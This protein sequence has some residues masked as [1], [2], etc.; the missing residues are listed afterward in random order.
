M[1]KKYVHIDQ[2]ETGYILADDVYDDRGLL[3]ISKD[4]AI[5]DYII[6]KLDNFDIR[7]LCVYEDH[8]MDKKKIRKQYIEHLKKDYKKNVDDMKQLMCDLASGRKLEYER[9]KRISDSVYSEVRYMINVP[10]FMNVVKDIDEYTYKHSI[11]VGIYAFLLAKWLGLEEEEIKNVVMTGILHD[12]GKA[13]VPVDILNKKGSLLPEEFEKIKEHTSIGY[14]LSLEI[15]QLSE[16]IREGILMHHE[17]ED[18]SGYPSGLRGNEIS[19]YA[20]IIAVADVYDALTSERAYKKR[21]TPFEAFKEII[22][23]GYSKFDTRILMTF[24]SNIYRYYIGTLVRMSNG[25]IGQIVFI[26]PEKISTPIVFL[27]GK[28]IDLSQMKYFKIEEVL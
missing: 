5:D 13:K 7:Q 11:N 16:E 22:R 27:N 28:Y 24:L 14:K 25:Q 8:Q 6:N 15:A 1:K 19:K 26:S 9:I 20:K 12:I 10:E 2:C 4:T 18:G 23:I 17:N 3:I 21:I